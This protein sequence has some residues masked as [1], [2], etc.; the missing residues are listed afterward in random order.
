M[1]VKKPDEMTVGDFVQQWYEA[2]EGN[3]RPNTRRYYKLLI[4]YFKNTGIMEIPL[5]GVTPPLV[6]KAV[7]QLPSHLKS[8]TRK[9]ACDLLRRIFNQAVEW[10][11]LAK[12]LFV[13][14]SYPK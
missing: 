5:T 11:M 2:T 6:Q 10:D 1:T 12:N 4:S 9:N 3:I 7:T 8:S 13:V 14:S